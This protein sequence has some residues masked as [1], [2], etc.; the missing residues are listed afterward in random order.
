MDC[1]RFYQGDDSDAHPDRGFPT[2]IDHP[3]RAKGV[4]FSAA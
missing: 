4:L 2:R 3:P 1:L